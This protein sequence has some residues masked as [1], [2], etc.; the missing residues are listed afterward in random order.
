MAT[1]CQP[2]FLP[3]QILFYLMSI[4]S[5]FTQR[6]TKAINSVQRHNAVPT[7]WYPRHQ[8]QQSPPPRQPPPKLGQQQRQLAPIPVTT[9][10]IGLANAEEREKQENKEKENRALEAPR[11][12]EPHSQETARTLLITLM[13]LMPHFH[14]DPMMLMMM[15]MYLQ[16]L[17]ELHKMRWKTRERKEWLWQLLLQRS[18]MQATL[19]SWLLRH[20]SFQF[21]V[22]QLPQGPSPGHN[23][24][25]QG[26]VTVDLQEKGDW[27]R[28][29]DL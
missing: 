29:Q 4:S 8:Q 25:H 10:P 18:S 11:K 6:N 7:I 13:N 5:Y 9:L 28:V 2:L 12:V 26:V 20:P 21:L 23:P 14:P 24:P 27:G 17:H 1:S 19:L 15:M 16:T 22:P 3:L